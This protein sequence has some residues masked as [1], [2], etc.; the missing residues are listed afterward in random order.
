MP[1]ANGFRGDN[2]LNQTHLSVIH[3]TSRS[4]VEAMGHS[5]ELGHLFKIRLELHASFLQQS[6]IR[7]TIGDQFFPKIKFVAFLSSCLV[8][9]FKFLPSRCRHAFFWVIVI[10][11]WH[12]THERLV[13]CRVKKMR[14]KSLLQ[15]PCLNAFIKHERGI[16]KKH[17]GSMNFN[18]STLMLRILAPFTIWSG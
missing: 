16:C 7:L 5:V 17:M 3:I 15:F 14:K 4:D 10:L 18:L 11:G 8:P 2:V 9:R 1:N 13:F 6:H 12:F